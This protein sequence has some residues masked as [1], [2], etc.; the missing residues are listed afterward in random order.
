[1]AK[2]MRITRSR[3]TTVTNYSLGKT[4]KDVD[5]FKDLGVKI[6]KYLS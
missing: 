5:S 3:D 1:M 2:L 4:L 6:T